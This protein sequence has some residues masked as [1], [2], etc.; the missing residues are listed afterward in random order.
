MNKKT[1]P[2][3]A[4]G[5]HSRWSG[6]PVG[7]FWDQSL[8][9]GLICLETLQTL[10]V[11]CHLLS[12]ADIAVGCLDRY[13]TLVVPGGWA[14]H[15]MRV[16]GE[17]GK[18]RIKDFIERGGSYL[19]FCGGAGLA[20]SSPPALG[21]VPL[22]RLSFSE[23]LPNASGEIWVKGAA[24]H[25]A[26]Q[27]LPALLP[28]SIW[29]PSQFRWQPLPDAVCLAAYEAT[30][31]DF[32]VADV[33][34]ADLEDHDISWEEWEKI[35]G[36]NLNPRRLL[37]HPAIIEVRSG[38]GS[39]VL[40]YPHLET[41]EDRWGNRLFSN[42]LNYLDGRASR[43][44]PSKTL[45][46]N[47]A[48]PHDTA[49][50]IPPGSKSLER[51]MNAL[52]L[53]D[54]LIRFGERHLLWR[55]RNPWLLHWRRG[56]RGLEYGTLAVSLRSVVARARELAA[57][58]EAGPLDPWLEPSI[59]LE[60]DVRMFCR[61]AQRLLLEEK[62]ATQSGRLKKLGT[63]ND[64]VDQLRARLFGNKMNYGGLC[65]MLF[66]RLDEFLLHVLRRRAPAMLP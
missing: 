55:W 35:Y 8:V 66:D 63:V 42:L 58:F 36:I 25:P 23:R 13:R 24:D 33:P 50:D 48:N 3:T 26:W 10:G 51:L 37:G 15:K 7:L 21:L 64:T 20:L 1:K 61:L 31:T 47:P 54:D 16:L 59:R 45:G 57:D 27:G 28:V 14:S 12:A 29:W 19:G 65:G 34:V 60:A 9:W 39:L 44:L 11:P 41:P 46:E 18:N 32:Q 2:D 38:M 30:G 53:A 40:S 5:A 52:N 6:P 22:E 43:F 62:L 4:D 17:E 49:C 56:I